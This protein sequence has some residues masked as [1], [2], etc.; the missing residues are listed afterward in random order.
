MH[1]WFKDEKRDEWFVICDKENKDFSPKEVCFDNNGRCP[2]CGE[3]A[4]A[5]MDKRK[6]EKLRKLREKE[7]FEESVKKNTLNYYF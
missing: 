5:E 6:K 4:K 7:V 2:H 1:K 3:N